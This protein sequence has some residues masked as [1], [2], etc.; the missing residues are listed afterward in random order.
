M[1]YKAIITDLDGSAVT[2]SSKGDDIAAKTIEAIDQAQA[3]GKVI[4]CATGRGWTYAKSVVRALGFKQPC[5]I[6]GGTRIIDPVTE[7][8]IWQKGMSDSTAQYVKSVFLEHAPD[9]LFVTSNRDNIDD[10][11]APELGN[12]QKDLFTTTKQST[13]TIKDVRYLYLL[14]VSLE[15]AKNIVNNVNQSPDAVAH[16]TLSWQ[17]DDLHDVHVT[18]RDATKEHA[19]NKWCELMGL[20]KEEVIGFGDSGNDIPIFEAVG[21]KIAAE[22]GTNEIIRLADYIAPPP[23]QDGLGHIIRKFLL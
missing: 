14:G 6:E 11:E 15:Q 20:E 22:S 10:K 1:T 2:I 3:Q 19:I 8:T 16:V 17:G 21:L 7:D 18:D 9:G 5:I 12:A 4:V 13:E 23:E